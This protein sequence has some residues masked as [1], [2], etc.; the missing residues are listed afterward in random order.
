MDVEGSAVDGITA[1]AAAP[2][3]TA[4]PLSAITQ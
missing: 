1:A 2:M 4:P 3:L